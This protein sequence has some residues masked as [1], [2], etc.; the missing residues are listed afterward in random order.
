MDSIVKD[1]K[2][3]VRPPLPPKG[4]ENLLTTSPPQPPPRRNKKPS[5][6][7]SNSSLNKKEQVRLIKII[8]RIKYK[9]YKQIIIYLSYYNCIKILTKFWPFS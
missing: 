7:S 8:V 6:L 3:G 9:K 2:G 1:V 5:F 4:S